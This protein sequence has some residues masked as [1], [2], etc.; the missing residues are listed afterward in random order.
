MKKFIL[1]TLIII[2]TFLNVSLAQDI[3]LS[4]NF[5]KTYMD[6]PCLYCT[7]PG[8]TIVTGGP[9][10]VSD[11]NK[12][13]GYLFKPWV[14]IFSQPP[15]Y[16]KAIDKNSAAV[17]LTLTNSD[18]KKDK[19]KAEA[20]GFE[21]GAQYTL[22]YY[23]MTAR[24]DLDAGPGVSQTDYASSATMEVKTVNSSGITSKTTTFSG[25]NV[26]TWIEETITFTAPA[27]NLTF[28]LSGASNGQQTSLVNFDIYS[29]PFDCVIPG[30]QVVLFHGG[31][32]PS[33]PFPCG[34]TNLF[35][36]ISS[37]TPVSPAG[38]V[39]VWGSNPNSSYPQLTEEQAKAAG[40]KASGQYYYAFYK[41]PGGCYNTYVSTAKASFTSTPTQVSLIANQRQL[42]VSI[43]PVSIL[44]PR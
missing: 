18:T 28:H 37:S 13:G 40:A 1:H 38:V 30:G 2:A 26:K 41:T 23:V 10:S 42:I 7:P 33:T 14:D 6:A 32:I 25:A 27:T 34:T 17:F 15:S 36:L 9:V 8:Y 43:K 11:I 16:G 44:M 24:A 3:N 21:I 35:D 31:A 4:V 12:V 29:K 20:S 22:H 19:V 39:P 5:P